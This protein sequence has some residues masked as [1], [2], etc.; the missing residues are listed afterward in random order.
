MSQS[1]PDWQAPTFEPWA[2]TMSPKG[3]RCVAY[4]RRSTSRQALTPEGQRAAIERACAERGWQLVATL[5][6][7]ESGGKGDRPVLATAVGLVEAGGA[8]ALVVAKLDRLARSTLDFLQ[9]VARARERGW[10]LVVLDPP[11]DMSTAAGR[12]CATMLAGVAEFELELIRQRTR[13]G[14]AV[15]RERG[16]QVNQGATPPDVVARIRREREA[17]MSLPAIAKGL[18]A[19]GVPTAQGG[20]QWY[21]STVSAVLRRT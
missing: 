16:E 10:A 6:E 11:L 19:D 14:L 3:T 2:G 21:P 15:K 1:S 13:E 17:G 5:E 4:V 18:N 7:T 8:D 12:M 9:L 20:R